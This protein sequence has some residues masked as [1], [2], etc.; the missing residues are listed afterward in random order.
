MSQSTLL[1]MNNVPGAQFRSELNTLLGALNTD[2]SGS[3]SPTTTAPYM[4]WLDTSVTPAVLKR[5]NAADSAWELTGGDSLKVALADT[6]DP[7][8]GAAMVGGVGRVIDSIS[9]LRALP[10]TGT[11]RVFVT[12]YYA[13]GDGGGGHYR[14]DSSDITS[15][16]NGGTVIVASDGGRWKLVQIS[17]ISIGQFGAKSDGSVDSSAQIQSSISA[18]GYIYSNGGIFLISSGLTADIA[19]FKMFGRGTI[20][21]TVASGYVFDIG[22]SAAGSDLFDVNITGWRFEKISGTDD[23]LRLRQCNLVEITSNVITGFAG[24]ALDLYGCD[25]A[26]ILRNRISSGS[27]RS[28]FEMDEL[29][30]RDNEIQSST[31]HPCIEAYGGNS[32]DISNNFINWSQNE[33]IIIG[34]DSVRGD[35][36]NALAIHSNYMERLCQN[37]TGSANRPFMHVGKPVDQNG[38]PYAGALV[39][40]W[41][42]VRHNYINADVSNGNLSNVIPCI[43]EYALEVDWDNNRVANFA[44]N[45]PRVKSPLKRFRIDTLENVTDISTSG[46]ASVQV[47]RTPQ[48]R[49]KTHEFYIARVAVTTDGTGAGSY[50]ATGL[51]TGLFGGFTA[52]DIYISALP[53]SDCRLYVSGKSISSGT[54]ADGSDQVS[55]TLNVRGGAVSSTVN[56]GVVAKIQ[57]T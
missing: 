36:P 28:A 49:Y 57:I 12:G 50:S 51:N 56:V 37:N 21:S 22:H 52:N 44:N 26:K 29:V 54:G 42:D 6:S 46:N 9:A 41:V 48:S 13:A 38:T 8:K 39:S 5:R 16:D 55:M 14:Y 3:V 17:P 15:A 40:T 53:E 18:I 43:F 10:K 27:I 35:F 25:G 4:T 19:S 23:C 2:F 1:Q 33:G 20:R 31:N 7:T 30:I 24:Y 47:W 45:N 32:I 34:Y 11:A